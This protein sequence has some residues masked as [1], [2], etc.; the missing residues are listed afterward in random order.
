MFAASC[1]KYPAQGWPTKQAEETSLQ[2]CCG[3]CKTSRSARCGERVSGRGSA[4]KERLYKRLSGDE[5]EFGE[6]RVQSDKGK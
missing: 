3:C 6:A 2:A 4:S 1:K 5:S